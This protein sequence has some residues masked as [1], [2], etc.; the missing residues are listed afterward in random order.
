MGIHCP[1]IHIIYSSWAKV[2]LQLVLANIASFLQESRLFLVVKL[3]AARSKHPGDGDGRP[4]WLDVT[5][6]ALLGRLCM[7]TKA[8]NAGNPQF[9]DPQ[10]IPRLPVGEVHLQYAW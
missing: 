10:W 5:N 2:N 9:I 4:L 7:A 1:G 6:D 3:G 8:R